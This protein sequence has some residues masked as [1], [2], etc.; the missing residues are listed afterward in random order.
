MKLFLMSV[1]F[2]VTV[3]VVIAALSNYLIINKLWKRRMKKDV[4]ESVSLGAALLGLFTGVPFLI[5]FTLIDHSP[6]PALKQA[7]GIV[8]A[9]VLL[10]IGSGVWVRENRGRGFS[11]L[12]LRALN[13]ERRESADLIKT[14]IQPKGAD[15]IL[16]ILEQLARVDRRIDQRE[17]ELIDEFAS[18]WKIDPPDLS[19]GA[20]DG[21]T[22]L[23]AVRDSLVEYLALDPPPEQASE[24]ADLLRVF[25][26]VDTEVSPEEETAV[27]ELN[28]LLA[29]YLH[30][31]GQSPTTYEVVIVP[32]NEEQIEAV[33]TLIPGAEMKPARGG[34]V[35]SVGR[36]FSRRYAEVICGRYI[37]LGLFT[38]HVESEL[39]AV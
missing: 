28:G 2:L 14:L 15:R 9:L 4:A 22:S 36:F 12:F 17:I 37:A 34:R 11:S 7:I 19:A 32:Q 38:T 3:S 13:L 6:M 1:R 18:R 20:A 25:V 33:R 24:L 8:T 21:E 26:R 30:L 16:R 29:R 5:Q 10:V 27:E 23:V 39:E 31:E 35:F